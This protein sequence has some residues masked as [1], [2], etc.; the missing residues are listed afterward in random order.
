M[1]RDP[2]KKREIPCRNETL[3][4]INLIKLA[5]SENFEGGPVKMRKQK[6]ITNQMLKKQMA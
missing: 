5:W 3:T 2:L 4:A 1:K 6:G